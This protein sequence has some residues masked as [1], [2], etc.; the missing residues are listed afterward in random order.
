[1]F[2]NHKNLVTPVDLLSVKL[3]FLSF[4]II[5]FNYTLKITYL[6]IKINL[7]QFDAIIITI[8]IIVK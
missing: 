1:M 4:L 6:I 3:V 7:L 8:F 2:G 5:F